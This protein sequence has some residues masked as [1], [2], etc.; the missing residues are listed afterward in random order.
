MAS[1]LGA[2]ALES[3][4][5]HAPESKAAGPP[6]GDDYRRELEQAEPMVQPMPPPPPDA[7]VTEDGVKLSV[8]QPGT[9]ASYHPDQASSVCVHYEARTRDGQLVASTYRSGSP[10]CTETMD[11]PPGV[12]EG[13][14]YMTLG[15][16]TRMWIPSRLAL[17]HDRGPSD[18]PLVYDVELLQ[19]L[20]TSPPRHLPE[21]TADR[22][23]R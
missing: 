15:E 14:T 21:N 11:L 22:F 17:M 18:E 6:A 13:V 5:W 1:N 20:A 23:S 2:C 9:A 7:V 10:R 16:K 3:N 12:R 8:L 4:A 19:I